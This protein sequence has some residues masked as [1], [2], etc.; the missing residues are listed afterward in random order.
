MVTR[1]CKYTLEILDF[2]H[3]NFL[4]QMHQR[5]GMISDNTTM[6]QD[7]ISWNGIGYYVHMH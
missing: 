7:F 4:V 5:F 1:I 3:K 2:S 6:Q